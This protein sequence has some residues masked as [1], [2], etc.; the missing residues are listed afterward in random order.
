MKIDA[1][2]SVLASAKLPPLTREQLLELAGTADGKQFQADLVRLQSGDES[3]AA[4][5]EV[6]VRSL[7]PSVQECLTGLGID[8]DVSAVLAVA[9]RERRGLFAAL[10]SIRERRPE[11]FAAIRYVKAL[12]QEASARPAPAPA[13]ALVA[14]PSAPPYYSFKIFGKSAA[15][16]FSEARTRAG[17]LHTIQI[18]GAGVLAGGGQAQFDWPNKIIVQLNTQEAYQTLALFENKVRSLKFDGHGARHDKSLHMEF[19]DSHYFVRMI[20]RGKPALAVPIS[21]ADAMKI[22]SLLYKQIQANEIHLDIA[23]IQRM[24]DRMAEMMQP[25]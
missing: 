7:S 2:T 13:A 15:L 4:D 9:R 24:V 11:R 17:N 6:V 20:Q 10:H 3:A 21:P 1:I 25:R 12:F 5:L 23:S 22:V 8:Y 14:V 18:E 19:Q 16:C